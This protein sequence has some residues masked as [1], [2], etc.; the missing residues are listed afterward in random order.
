[1]HE[2]ASDLIFFLSRL[3]IHLHIWSLRLAHDSPRIRIAV[4]CKV[5][6]M[7][8]PNWAQSANKITGNR[9]WRVLRVSLHSICDPVADAINSGSA[10]RHSF[11]SLFSFLLFRFP[12][13]V[14]ILRDHFN[15]S[16]IASL[17]SWTTQQERKMK[18]ERKMAQFFAIHTHR[19]LVMQWRRCLSTAPRTLQLQRREN[20]R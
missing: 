20:Y 13:L 10:G 12:S 14:L 5:P 9:W 11:Q 2:K 18:T 7:K 4:S 17:T 3:F 8:W 1:M 19:K 15:K 6:I 16:N